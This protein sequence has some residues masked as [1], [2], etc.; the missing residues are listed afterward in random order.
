MVGTSWFLFGKCSM[1]GHSYSL[2]PRRTTTESCVFERVIHFLIENQE[3]SE[4]HRVWDD[5]SEG[6]EFQTMFFTATFL[7]LLL[8]HCSR[9][10]N[11][12]SQQYSALSFSATFIRLKIFPAPSPGNSTQ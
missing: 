2:P 1:S 3:T 12:V 9:Q 5:T 6:T 4:K 11:V 7:I 8:R 10:T